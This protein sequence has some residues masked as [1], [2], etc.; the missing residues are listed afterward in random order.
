MRR[1][2]KVSLGIVGVILIAV[3]IGVGWFAGKIGPI[4]SGFVAKYICSSTF[5]SGRDPETVFTKT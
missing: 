3:G 5:I 1:W 2:I 4:G